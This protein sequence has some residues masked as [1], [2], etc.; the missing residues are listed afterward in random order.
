MLEWSCPCGCGIYTTRPTRGTVDVQPLHGPLAEL[1]GLAPGS[2]GLLYGARGSGKSTMALQAFER[3]WVL[4]TEMEPALVLAYA[5]RLGVS[6]AGVRELERDDNG[7]LVAELAEGGQ[8][9]GLIVD[10]LNGLGQPE[11][12]FMWSR[13][14]A[15]ALGVPLLAIAQ[16]TTDERVRGG[17]LVPHLAHV[18]IR[19]AKTAV[20]RELV[21]EK[22]R[23]GPERSIPWCMDGERAPPYFYVVG[24]K[25][26]S[27]R[28]Q[29]HPWA[30]SKVWDAVINGD[31]GRPERPAAAAAEWSPL[32]NGFVEPPDWRERQRF[33][34]ARGVQY[35]KVGYGE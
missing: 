23:F 24:G 19:C 26:G 6:P 28:L 7:D 17:E 31:L 8:A 12:V 33:C 5:Q 34:A 21:I 29:A 4:S 14:A 20:G 13:D 15:V 1:E 2:A 11:Q 3:P 35:Y 18:L 22:N 25:R 32:Y 10:S 30:A 9:D 27:Y 16:I